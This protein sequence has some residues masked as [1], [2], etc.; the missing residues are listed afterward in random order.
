MEIDAKKPLECTKRRGTTLPLGEKVDGRE[1]C[2]KGTSLLVPQTLTPRRRALALAT[3][4]A[5]RFTF[6]P[7]C[8]V[9]P[10]RDPF[11][12]AGFSPCGKVEKI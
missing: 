7:S 4:R 5:P 8:L 3:F 6:S 1:L 2:N 11:K 9:V 12:M 10:Q